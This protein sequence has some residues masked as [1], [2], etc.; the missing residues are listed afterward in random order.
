MSSAG[1]VYILT[2][3]ALPGLLKI[4]KTTRTPQLRAE[5]LSKPT[6]VPMPF[7]VAYSLYGIDCH[8]VEKRVHQQLSTVRVRGRE[9]FELPLGEAIAVVD[10]VGAPYLPTATRARQRLR[11]ILGDTLGDLVSGVFALVWYFTRVALALLAGVALG[12][13]SLAA[14]LLLIG[15]LVI[16]CVHSPP[17]CLQNFAM[18]DANITRSQ[19]REQCKTA[20]CRAE[21]R[22]QRARARRKARRQ[23]RSQRNDKAP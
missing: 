17:G 21:V 5:E 4:G 8:R 15:A 11:R 19:S 23:I 14:K 3:P 1:Y 9:F 22:K 10:S 16:W 6:G 20:K 12:V 18:P 13:G 2:N 7:E